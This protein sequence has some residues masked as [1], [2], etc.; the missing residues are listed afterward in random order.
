MAVPAMTVA[1]LAA[2]PVKGLRLLAASE[3]RLGP[4]G[5][6]GNRRFYLIDDR[7]SMVNG[8]QLGALNAVVPAYDESAGR[9][10]L[11]FPDGTEATG[12]VELG[13][14][15]G[16]R[17]FSR[18]APARLVVGP[19]SDALS[20]HAG[21]PLRLVAPAAGRLG[22]D[23][24]RAGGVTLVSRASVRRLAEVAGVGELDVRRFR[25]SIELD[26]PTAHAEDGWVDRRLRI[27]E[28]LV[29]VRGHVGR[30]LVTTR[31]P[32]T[33]AVDLPVLELLRSYRAGLDTTE[34]L[35]F[36]VH[37]EVLEPGR[38]C[39]GDSATLV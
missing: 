6:A 2:T 39:P 22:V 37:A 36:G 16:T 29:R 13:P 12:P 26:G 19:W 33:G 14:P 7:G 35:A 27:G 30:C 9:L 15:V 5:V 11:R 17:F 38:I 3:L 32:D 23:R 1:G 21:R 25:M 20:A 24:G 18:P 10:T 31:D 8:K 34:P 4:G 28:A